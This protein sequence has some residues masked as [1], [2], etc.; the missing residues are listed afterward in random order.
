MDSE[1]KQPCRTM[2]VPQAGRHYY[3]LG[4]NASY[5]A[6]RRG[7]IPVIKIGRLLRVPVPAMERRLEVVR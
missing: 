4:R 2:S 6:V 5:A 3:N 7:D 1:P